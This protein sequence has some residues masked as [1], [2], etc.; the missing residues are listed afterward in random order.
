MSG[1]PVDARQQD[2]VNSADPGKWIALLRERGYEQAARVLET[3]DRSP[4]AT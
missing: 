1:L 3:L 2:A 4:G